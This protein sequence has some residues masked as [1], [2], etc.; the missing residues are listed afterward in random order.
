MGT[1][2]AR[3]AW[4]KAGEEVWGPIWLRLK[5]WSS[6]GGRELGKRIKLASERIRFAFQKHSSPG[7][8]RGWAR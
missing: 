1:G 8:G 6:T 7:G 2:G 5:S 4:S 3:L